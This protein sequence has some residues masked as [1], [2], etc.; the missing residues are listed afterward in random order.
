[1]LT[2]LVS[3]L[4]LSCTPGISEAA[5]PPQDRLGLLS[6]VFALVCTSTLIINYIYTLLFNYYH[7]P[8]SLITII[9]PP[10]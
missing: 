5:L 8:S 4:S 3:A 10:L 6:D 9:Y 2:P 1:M 7:I